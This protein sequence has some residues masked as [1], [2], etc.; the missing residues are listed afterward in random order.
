MKALQK[1][2][3]ATTIALLAILPAP[4]AFAAGGDMSITSENIRFGINNPLEGQ[5]NTIYATVSNSSPND[6]LGT[7]RFFVDGKQIQG[8]QPISIFGEASDGVFVNWIGTPGNHVIEVVI[9]PWDNSEDNAANNRIS[10]SKY[11][12]PDLDRDGIP[13]AKDPDIDGDGVNN[14]D[15]HFP[16]NPNE[17]LDTDGDGMGNN[18]DKDDDND[19]VPDEF[20]DLPLDPNESLDTDKDGIGNITDGDDDNDGISDNDEEKFGT[21]PANA[22]TDIDGANDGEDDFPNDPEEQLDTDKDKIG[23]KLDTDDDNDGIRDED[24]EFPLN[25]GAIIEISD[26]EQTIGLMEKHVFDAT[27]SYDEDGKIV[28][29]LWEID[30]QTSQEGNA[31]T[32]TFSEPGNHMVKLS[33]IDDKGQKVTKEFQVNVVNLSLYRQMIATLLVICL[34]S[35]IYFKYIFAR[36]RNDRQEKQAKK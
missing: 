31:I 34:A 30:S 19:E 8:D 5:V 22:D 23:N 4:T 33:L 29:Y 16:R 36:R 10:T 13:D 1:G 11:V 32:H 9:L 12:I 24:D 25:K 17:Q 21:D 15:D 18:T 28:N 35:I 2:L 26:D 14:E 7:V 3:I 27:P 6:L 20:D